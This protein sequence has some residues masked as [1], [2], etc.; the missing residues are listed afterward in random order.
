MV[1]AYP[2]ILTRVLMNVISSVDCSV[3]NLMCSEHVLRT[4]VHVCDEPFKFNRLV[5]P[6]HKDVIYISQVQQ[7]LV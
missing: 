3:V 2:C 7:G 4:C 5:L 6:E 1:R